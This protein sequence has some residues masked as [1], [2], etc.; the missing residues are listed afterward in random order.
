L[1]SSALAFSLLIGHLLGDAVS[2]AIVGVLATNFDPT[3]G[4]HF[5]QALAGGDLT[6]AIAYTC[7]PA[8]AIAGLVGIVGA[9][10]LKSDVVAAEKA[11]QIARAE[12]AVSAM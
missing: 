10:W 2:P 9:R 3:H 11:E 6:L 4:E 7:V 5:R 1:R 8:I 12:A